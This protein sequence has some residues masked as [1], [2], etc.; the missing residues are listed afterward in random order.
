M[1]PTVPL[2]GSGWD[3]WIADRPNV[4]SPSYEHLGHT[5]TVPSGIRSDPFLTGKNNK[6]NYF[7]ANEIEPLYEKAG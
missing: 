2:F 1:H 7:G 5:Y 4:K 6:S 3:L